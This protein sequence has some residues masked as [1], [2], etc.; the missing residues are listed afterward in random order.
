M[1]I[2]PIHLVLRS[3]KPADFDIVAWRENIER[4]LKPRNITQTLDEYL[5][6]E[7]SILLHPELQSY[8]DLTEEQKS[9]IPESE[10]KLFVMEYDLRD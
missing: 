7:T 3:V 1:T 10:F 9:N 8:D 6:G 2:E 4:S 5:K